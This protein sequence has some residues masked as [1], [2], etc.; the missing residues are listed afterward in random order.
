ME[1]GVAV[2]HGVLVD[3]DEL[4]LAAGVLTEPIDWG[5]L[6]GSRVEIVILFAVPEGRLRDYQRALGELMGLLIDPERRR[7][8]ARRAHEGRST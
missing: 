1:M 5:T 8:L 4:R 3:G 2:P 6:D 7:A